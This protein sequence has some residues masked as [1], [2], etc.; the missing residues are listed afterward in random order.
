MD[1]LSEDNKREI[2][3]WL[4]GND[5]TSFANTSTNI[6]NLI[7]PEARIRNPYEAYWY[8]VVTTRL[9]STVQQYIN[10]QLNPVVRKDLRFMLGNGYMLD[11]EFNDNNLCVNYHNGTNVRGDCSIIKPLFDKSYSYAYSES[12]PKNERYPL[13]LYVG[14]IFSRRNICCG[15]LITK[16]EMCQFFAMLTVLVARKFEITDALWRD[17]DFVRPKKPYTTWPNFI[18]KVR[19]AEPT[20]EVSTK[21]SASPQV[22][23]KVL[24]QVLTQAPMKDTSVFTQRRKVINQQKVRGH[25]EVMELHEKGRL[26]VEIKND[27]V[28][29]LAKLAKVGSNPAWGGKRLKKNKDVKKCT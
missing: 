18:A 5:V 13:G 4:R 3:R 28:S 2:L 26:E 20:Y 27:R 14:D 17:N 6:R 11:I 22:F 29:N 23:T 19:K 1:N 12:E 10:K 7:T 8:E 9:Y 15:I 24:S 21:S 16:R 25:K